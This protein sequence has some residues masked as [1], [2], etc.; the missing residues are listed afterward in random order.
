MYCCFTKR[1]L[2]SLFVKN[3]RKYEYNKKKDNMSIIGNNK[4]K[5]V[6]HGYSNDIKPTD[7]INGL[8]S[9]CLCEIHIA[10]SNAPSRLVL[11]YVNISIDNKLIKGDA[12]HI[13]NIT[14]KTINDIYDITQYDIYNAIQDYI[15]IYKTIPSNDKIIIPT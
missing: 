10:I 5:C 11:S 3:Q 8:N 13:Y 2:L 9:L 1:D 7:I 14:Y 12:F 4:P 15:Y 6:Y